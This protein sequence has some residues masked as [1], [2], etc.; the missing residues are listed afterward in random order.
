MGRGGEKL[1]HTGMR[2]IAV[3]S[4]PDT[5]KARAKVLWQTLRKSEEVSGLKERR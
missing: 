3:K 2:D 5:R 1:Q 4:I